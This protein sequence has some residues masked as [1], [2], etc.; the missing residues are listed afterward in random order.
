M[1][2]EVEVTEYLDEIRKEVCSRCVERPPDGPPCAPLGKDCG[3]EMHLPQLIDSIR[4]V[5]SDAIA[6]YVD[7]NRRLICETCPQL[8]GE[9]CPCPMEYLAVLVVEAVETVDRRHNPAQVP[10][11]GATRER[12]IAA[13]RITLTVTGGQ[14][15]GEQFT[16]DGRTI[17]CAGRGPHCQ[18]RFCGDPSDQLISRNHCL[19]DIDPPAIRVQDLGSL[20]GTYVN[21][22]CIGGGDRTQVSGQGTD[23]AEVS[24][25]DGDV[26]RLGDVVLHVHV[27]AAEADGAADR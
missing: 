18:V 1:L 17:F 21:G 27:T 4:A 16:F 26:L 22:R 11:Q 9:N 3:I 12:R 20:N 14:H 13:A 25:K 2:T 19:L 6:P 8:N 10:S 5:H 7:N 24:L 15:Q 23:D